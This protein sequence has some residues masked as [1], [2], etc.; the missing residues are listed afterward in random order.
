MPY[1]SSA[2]ARSLAHSLYRADY[3]VAALTETFGTAALSALQQG[4]AAPIRRSLHA[5]ATPMAIVTRLFW[6]GDLCARPEVE[7]ALQSVALGELEASGIVETEGNAVRA[8]IAI[9]PYAYQDAH[10]AGEWWIASDLDEVAGVAPL[11]SDHVLGVG[12]AGRTLASLLPPLHVKHSLDMGCGCGI[13]SL[14][15]RRFSD[16]VTATDISERA[17]WFTNLTADLNGVDCINTR[18]GSLFDPVAG[19]RFG[20]VA[21]NPPFVVTPRVEGVPTYEYRDGGATGDALMAN[22]LSGLHAVLDDGGVAVLLGNWEE[23]IDTSGLDRVQTWTGNLDTWIIERENID[24]VGYA[25]LWARDGGSR[26]GTDDYDSLV[27]AWL[28]DFD[29]RE[30][31]GIGMGWIVARRPLGGKTLARSERLAHHMPTDMPGVHVLDAIRAHDELSETNDDALESTY[32]FVSADVTEARHHM[33]GSESPSVIEL[34]QGGS[35]GRSVEVDPALAGFVGACDGDLT[36]GAIIG[37]LAQIL[38]VDRSALTADLLPRVRELIFTGFLSL[39]RA[40]GSAA[41]DR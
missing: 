2:L 8:L 29:S 10:G 38:E 4:D 28:D 37:A 21:S 1:V 24:P 6:L 40:A 33:P 7:N 23:R 30:V 36:V 25:R 22:V 34:R 18:V 3:T 17:V 12:G 11:R 16:E 31:S 39:P 5:V 32:L 27:A 14:H 26:P 15:L 13:L 20:I 9:R 35:F 19:E 41:T